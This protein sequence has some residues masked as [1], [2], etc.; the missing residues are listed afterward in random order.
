VVK[1][2]SILD[3]TEQGK[4]GTL[5]LMT[6]LVSHHLQTVPELP[7]LDIQFLHLTMLQK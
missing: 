2:G 4:M 6:T 1:Q 5:E 7:W 3:S